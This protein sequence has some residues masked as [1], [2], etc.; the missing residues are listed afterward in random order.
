MFMVT[1]FVVPVSKEPAG[2]TVF[3]IYVKAVA[4][5]TVIEY[6]PS[7]KLFDNPC[8]PICAFVAKPCAEEHVTVITVVPIDDTDNNGS[9]TAHCVSITKGIWAFCV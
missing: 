9:F 1:M 4:V 7:A 8:T 2:I 6:A 3:V 5:V